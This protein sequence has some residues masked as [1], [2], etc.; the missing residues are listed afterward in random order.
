MTTVI[1]FGD[2]VSALCENLPELY[3]D[4]DVKLTC[5]VAVEPISFDLAPATSLG[6]VITELVSNAYMHAFPPK[7]S[8]EIVVTLRVGTGA[9]SLSVSDNGVGFVPTE[10]KR[11]GV[12]LVRRLVA[13][14]GATMNMRS[15][16][17]TTWTID[18]SIPKTST[19]LAA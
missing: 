15:D 18:F 14:V 17:G 13:Q 5:S 4:Q 6:I 10:T 9:A 11:R 8:G 19:P 16:Y 3:K 7:G 1:N 2:Y 12:G